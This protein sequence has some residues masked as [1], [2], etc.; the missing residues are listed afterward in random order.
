MNFYFVETVEDETGKILM[1]LLFWREQEIKV[2][3][4]VNF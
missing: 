4:V 1:Q 2:S 3:S